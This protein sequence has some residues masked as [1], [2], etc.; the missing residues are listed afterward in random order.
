MARLAAR[1]PAYGFG[2]NAGY[3]TAAHLSALAAD[4]PC[5]FHRTTFAPV[6]GAQA[7][8]R[9]PFRCVLLKPVPDLIR[10]RRRITSG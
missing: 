6:R 2:T 8:R 9:K 10:R 7:L 4:G 3:G 5:P 1:Y